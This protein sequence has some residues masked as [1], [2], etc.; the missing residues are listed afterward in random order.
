MKYTNTIPKVP[1]EERS[2]VIRTAAPREYMPT[3]LSR[4]RTSIEEGYICGEGS[5]IKPFDE[6]PCTYQFYYTK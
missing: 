1:S 2:L 6:A 4:V 3:I 5:V